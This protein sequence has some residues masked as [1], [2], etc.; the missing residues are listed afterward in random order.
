MYALGSEPPIRKY[1]PSQPWS[2]HRRPHEAGGLHPEFLRRIA[3]RYS[4]ANFGRWKRATD[5][6]NRQF[7]THKHFGLLNSEFAPSKCETLRAS[8][9]PIVAVQNLGFFAVGLY[10]RADTAFGRQLDFDI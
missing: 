6:S 4:A 7:D 10:R 9:K 8:P 3:A 2:H 1:P 5:R